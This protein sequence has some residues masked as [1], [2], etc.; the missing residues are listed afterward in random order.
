MKA[1][2]S[3]PYEGLWQGYEGEWLHVSR[4]LVALA[5]AIPEDGYGWRPAEGCRAVSEAINHVTLANFYLLHFAGGAL[6][7]E[8]DGQHMEKAVTDKEE[9]IGWLRRSLAAVDAAR[10]A[11]TPETLGAERTILGRAATVDGIHLRIL[12]HANEHLG[13]LVAYARSMGIVPPWS[14]S[15]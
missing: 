5:E 8:L 4:Y 2:E 15:Q 6:P 14:S 7:A 1:H 11:A 9:V 12:V 3:D 10:V 13:Q